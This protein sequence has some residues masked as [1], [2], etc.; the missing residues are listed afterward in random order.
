[1]LPVKDVE[2]WFPCS[3]LTLTNAA[4][5]GLKA[6]ARELN[7]DY[8]WNEVYYSNKREKNLSGVSFINKD[9]L[10]WKSRGIWPF[11]RILSAELAKNSLLKIILQTLQTQMWHRFP[12]INVLLFELGSVVFFFF[13][14][15]RQKYPCSYSQIIEYMYT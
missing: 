2:F 9:S 6:A 15:V 5:R 8:T 4:E 11:V 14:D 13:P 7:A 12:M 3:R 1:M 10:N